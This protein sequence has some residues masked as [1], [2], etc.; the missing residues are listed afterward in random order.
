MAR[1]LNAIANDDTVQTNPGIDLN[2]GGQN[3]YTG[4]VTI[5][6]DNG[7]IGESWLSNQSYVQR[8]LVPVL[9]SS[10]KLFKYAST[11]EGKKL[12]KTLKAIVEQ[13]PLTVT[14]LNATLETAWEESQ[15][16][17]NGQMQEDLTDVTRARSSVN[18]TFKE[19]AG[20]PFRRFFE[21]WIKYGLMDP[22]GKSPLVSSLKK[23]RD[24]KTIKVYTPDYYTMTML[25]FEPDI[26]NRFI[27]EAWLCFNMAPKSTG[28]IEV[29]EINIMLV[30]NIT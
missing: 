22:D 3:G 24:D 20:V 27:V 4:A 13:H 19:K 2:Y 10:P 16:G 11:D 6:D 12:V 7:V 30:Q 28:P 15:S 14:G 8:N 29:K 25:Y 18:M 17:I 5:T 21:F 23:Y 1:F 26:T 9:V